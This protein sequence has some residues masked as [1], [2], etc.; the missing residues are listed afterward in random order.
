MKCQGIFFCLCVPACCALQ[1]CRF[2]CS[3]ANQWGYDIVA[4][5]VGEYTY[6]RWIHPHVGA[7]LRDVSGVMYVTNI[8]C[9][10]KDI[11]V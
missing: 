8:A 1:Q 5:I 6:C 3:V 7:S 2:F 10:L 9:S 11:A 4:G